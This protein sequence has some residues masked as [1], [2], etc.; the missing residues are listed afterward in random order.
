MPDIS[1]PVTMFSCRW[2]AAIHAH[3]VHA[4]P[5]SAANFIFQRDVAAPSSDATIDCLPQAHNRRR[6]RFTSFTPLLQHHP[7]FPRPSMSDT[8]RPP[9]QRPAQWQ[10]QQA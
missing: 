2:L 10:A 4:R 3:Y 6:H 7:P 9:A 8:C 5:S 1:P